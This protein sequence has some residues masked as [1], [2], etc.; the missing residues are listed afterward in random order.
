M[1]GRLFPAVYD[2]AF[3]SLRRH[4]PDQVQGFKAFSRFLSA[5]TTQH[6][7]YVVNLPKKRKTVNMSGIKN[8]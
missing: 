8:F 7:I 1:T 3:L 4:Y 2:S 5:G 6:P